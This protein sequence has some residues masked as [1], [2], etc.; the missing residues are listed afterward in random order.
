MSHVPTM[1]S[2]MSMRSCSFT[3]R[4]DG[5]CDLFRVRHIEPDLNVALRVTPH[6]LLRLLR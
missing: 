5:T 2:S 6:T 1:L 3:A 4:V